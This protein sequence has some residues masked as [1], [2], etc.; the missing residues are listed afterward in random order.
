[1]LDDVNPR[2]AKFFSSDLDDLQKRPDRAVGGQF[3]PS[4]PWHRHCGY[5]CCGGMISEVELPA[6]KRAKD[7]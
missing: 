3:P 4:P 6:E 2:T 5:L 1:M 7:N